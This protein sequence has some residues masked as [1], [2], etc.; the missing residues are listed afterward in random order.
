M[1]EE[2]T[3]LEEMIQRETQLKIQRY[4]RLNQLAQKGKIVLTGSS[5]ME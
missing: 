2:Q 4:H 3:R 5:L 1:S